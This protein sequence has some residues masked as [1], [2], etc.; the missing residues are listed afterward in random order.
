[1]R[2]GSKTNAP[3]DGLKIRVIALPPGP[4]L[5]RDDFSL[6]GVWR[7]DSPFTRDATGILVAQIWSQTAHERR[8]AAQNA[9]ERDF[10]TASAMT[11]ILNPNFLWKFLHQKPII[12]TL[13]QVFYPI[14]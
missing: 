11:Q 13:R 7:R 8:L 10:A 14:F 6:N 12:W 9:G 4:T 2:F 5:F 3:K 1:M